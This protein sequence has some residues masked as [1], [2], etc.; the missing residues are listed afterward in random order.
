[1][2]RAVRRSLLVLAGVVGL[3]AVTAGTAAAGASLNHAE[4]ALDRRGEP[5]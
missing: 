5:R 2:R 4:P 3:I 1:M